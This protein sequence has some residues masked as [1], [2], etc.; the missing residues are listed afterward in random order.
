MHPPQR[1][2]KSHA[3]ELKFGETTYVQNTSYFLGQLR[4]GQ[5]L[6]S[7]ENNLY[8]IPIYPHSV[9]P[10]DFLLIVSGDKV[11]IRKA[12]AIFLEGQQCPKVEVPAPNSKS[13]AA[14]LKDLLQVSV[15]VASSSLH[16]HRSPLKHLRTHAHTR[17][18]CI[19]CS[20]KVMNLPRG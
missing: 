15:S 14:F 9:P 4:P 3:P 16:I 10:T 12:S 19:V 2:L 5:T 1:Q 7:F 11:Y 6:Q 8:R 18:I 13:S 17:Y 20:V